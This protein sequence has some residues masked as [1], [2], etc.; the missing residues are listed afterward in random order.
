MFIIV[1]V[2]DKNIQNR[3]LFLMVNNTK[4]K[5]KNLIKKIDIKMV[6]GYIE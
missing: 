1:M 2:T 3:S 4:K 5:L 6:V